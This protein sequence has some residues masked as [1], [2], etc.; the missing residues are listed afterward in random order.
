MIEKNIIMRT[1]DLSR[2]NLIELPELPK[3][4]TSLWISRNKI[5]DI[6]KLE[7]LSDLRILFLHDNPVEDI[8]PLSNL[9]NLRTLNISNTK[10]DDLTA[11]KNLVPTA[12]VLV[13]IMLLLIF[14]C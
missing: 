3:D 4:L 5:H 12:F 7:N 14:L 11:L 1:L 13:V 8:S 9:K 2:K 10:I 6:S